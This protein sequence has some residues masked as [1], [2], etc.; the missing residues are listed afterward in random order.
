[1]LQT[2]KKFVMMFFKIAKCFDVLPN[3]IKIINHAKKKLKH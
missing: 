1:M 2:L 3:A